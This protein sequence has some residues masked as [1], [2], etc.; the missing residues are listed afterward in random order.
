[1]RTSVRHPKA[2]VIAFAAACTCVALTCG[3]QGYP[4]KPIRMV[5]PFPAGGGADIVARALSPSL[6][7]SLGQSVIVDNR[8]GADG[9]IGAAQVAKSPPDGYTLLV[10]TTGPM[11]I[12]PALEP[13]M[14]YD[15]LRDFAPVTQL[16][17]QPIALIVHPS[18][19]VSTVSQFVAFAKARPGQLNY[20]SSGIGGGTHLGAEIFSWLTGIKMVHVPYKGTAQATTDLISGQV[21]VLFTSVSV[22]LPHIQ[23]QRL[24]ALAV[25][26]EKRLSMLPQVPTMAEGGVKGFDAS[27][28]YGLFAPAGTPA[29]IVRRL[30]A[31]TVGAL[32]S[33]DIEKLLSSQGAFPVGSSSEHFQAHIRAELVKW[34]KTVDAAGV[35][36]H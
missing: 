36:P 20:G 26:S 9:Q 31:E 4:V 30:N 25:G 7:A 27:S 15:T 21:Q 29:E 14:A 10:G 3:A 17:T 16:I 8:P 6:S 11:V 22:V 32:K 34:K 1:M 19:P 23:S 2:A 35:K 5:V 24:K 13:K 33:P 18:L 28:W 12:N